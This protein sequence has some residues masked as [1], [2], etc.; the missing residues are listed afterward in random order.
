VYSW[1]SVWVP[2]DIRVW[3]RSRNREKS[4]T[5]TMSS[6]AFSFRPMEHAD[7]PMFLGWIAR[8]HEAEFWHDPPHPNNRRAIRCCEKAGFH[9]VREVATP[10]GPALLMYC[11]RPP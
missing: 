5:V 4:P 10:D 9:A 7:I 3:G 2:V 8:S 11:E 6:A 1:K